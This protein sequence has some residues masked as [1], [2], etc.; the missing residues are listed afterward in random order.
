[1]TAT[2]LIHGNSSSEIASTIEAAIRQGSLAA[3]DPLPTVRGLA[4]SLDV[5][6]TT[7]AAA[8][9]ELR[10]RGLLV[11]QGRRG[12]RVCPRPPIY[13]GPDV[14]LPMGVTAAVTGSIRSS[15][16]CPMSTP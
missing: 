8:Y 1:M 11:T 10:A 3:G 7:V 14:P 13:T 4:G 9:K 5:S 12:T 16:F 15:C 6:P 2:N